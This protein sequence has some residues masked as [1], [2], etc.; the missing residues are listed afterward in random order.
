M[1][2]ISILIPT[3]REKDALDLCLK[4]CIEGCTDLNQIE[5][6]VG[7]DGFYEEN[8][9]ILDKYK[10][11]ISILNLPENLG[12]IKMMNLL[13]YNASNNLLLHIQDDNV[14]PFGYNEKLLNNYQPGIVL[15]PNQIEPTPSMFK[16][17]HIKNLGL[18]K[19]L[20]TFD[21]EAFWKYEKEI[22]KSY[23][24]ED[25]STFPF[26][27]SKQDYLKVGGFD[28]SYPSPWV[29][30]CEFFMKCKMIGLQMLRT[31]NCHFYHFVS[32]GTVPTQ[33]KMLEKQYKEME[34]HEYFRYK[35]GNYMKRNLDNSIFY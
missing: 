3:Y 20:K 15:T 1:N 8:K 26:L 9:E 4:S 30:D 12:M 21:L 31:Y 33:E 32:L 11:Y 35:W 27:I 29:V 6:I 13:S 19:D 7:V 10:K 16:Q 5:I 14:F 22:S 34:S 2:K 17:F 28:E 25:G 24:S 18:G 23:I